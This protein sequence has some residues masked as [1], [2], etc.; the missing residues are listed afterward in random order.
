[1]SALTHRHIHPAGDHV[2]P[3]G[4]LL[5]LFTRIL[6]RCADSPLHSTVVRT[7]PL[8]TPALPPRTATFA[9]TQL[10]AHW[11]AVIDDD[12]RPRL[13]ARWRPRV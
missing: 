2:R 3:V 11:H 12:G 5:A 8:R 10:Q 9:P 6:R 7:R 4:G 13:E 1:M